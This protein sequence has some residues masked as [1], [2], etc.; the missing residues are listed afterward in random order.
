VFIDV[1]DVVVSGSVV[2][3]SGSVV[4]IDVVN[5]STRTSTCTRTKGSSRWSSR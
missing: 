4:V 1:V 5:V 3:V 2:V